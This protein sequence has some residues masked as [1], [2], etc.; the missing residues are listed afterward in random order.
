MI[1]LSATPSI[2]SVDPHRWRG[3]KPLVA[4]DDDMPYLLSA[5]VTRGP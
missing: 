4:Q 1:H 5:T 3:F 2:V